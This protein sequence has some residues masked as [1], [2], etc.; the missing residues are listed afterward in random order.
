M[1]VSED[2]SF[3]CTKSKNSTGMVSFGTVAEQMLYEIGDPQ[4]YIL[5]DVICDFSNVKI[6]ET[7]KI[8]LKSLEQKVIQ[9]LINIKF[10]QHTLM[11]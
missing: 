2:G 1:E 3:D 6:E 10:A 5:P 4:A 11:V 7:E 9:L 8:K